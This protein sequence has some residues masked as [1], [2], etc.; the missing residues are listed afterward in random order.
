MSWQSTWNEAAKQQTG[1]WV[2]FILTCLLTFKLIICKIQTLQHSKKQ[3]TIQRLLRTENYMHYP[4][5]QYTNTKPHNW[6]KRHNTKIQKTVFWY[7]FFSENKIYKIINKDKM[8]SNN[9][10]SIGDQTQETSPR[11]TNWT[12]TWKNQPS[13]NP[14]K[15][16]P[17]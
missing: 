17:T 8:V 15:R 11:N 9:H 6:A 5:I 1:K 13:H 10:R 16:T 14:T 12:F 2:A 3:F 4:I 7:T